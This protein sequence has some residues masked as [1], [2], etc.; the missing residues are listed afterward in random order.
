MENSLKFVPSLS[1]LNFYIEHNMESGKNI[2]PWKVVSRE[3]LWRRPWLTVRKE[4]VELP[5]GN[6]IPEYYVLEY[7]EWVN[8]LA[9]TR[10]KQLVMIRQWRHGLGRAD[11][12]LPAGVCER[13]DASPLES[14][15]REL[16]EETG[17]GGG[18]WEE[19]MVVSANPSTHTNLTHCF[20][21]TDVE[22]TSDPHPEATEDLSVHLLDP[23]QVKRLLLSD[24]IKQALHAAPL[25]KYMAM[26][27][28]L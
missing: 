5:S 24:K 26:N 1:R 28:L 8:I 2:L 9:I 22:M 16:A 23:E 13:E 21:A 19:F 12:E 27:R 25:W 4:C 18:Q 20:L 6:R 15:R 7:P 11:F 17:Y 3:Y 10:D 14:A